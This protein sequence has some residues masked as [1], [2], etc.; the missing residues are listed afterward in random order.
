MRDDCLLFFRSM[1]WSMYYTEFRV[2]VVMVLCLSQCWTSVE[3]KRW[4]MKVKSKKL[5]NIAGSLL[6]S[7][8]GRG[9]GMMRLLR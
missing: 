6:Y 5:L 4:T 9:W 1:P 2:L 3:I 7:T 8:I